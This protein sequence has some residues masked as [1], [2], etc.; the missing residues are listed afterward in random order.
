MTARRRDHRFGMRI[1]SIGIVILSVVH[2]PLPQADYHNVR[3]HDGPGE[4]CAHHDHLLR[5]HPSAGTGADLTLLHWHW[6]LPLLEPANSH[7]RPDDDHHRPGSGPA[8][9]AHVGDGLTPEDWR[10]EPVIES[11]GSWRMIDRLVLDSS[12]FARADHLSIPFSIDAPP[13]VLLGRADTKR[14]A[15]NA[16]GLIYRAG[17]AEAASRAP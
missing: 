8:L 3:H 16:N 17:T 4:I 6:F 2:I 14:A 7:D 5:W 11:A 12:T 1:L 9:H 13:G 15:Q 10:G